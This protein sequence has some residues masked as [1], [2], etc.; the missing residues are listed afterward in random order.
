MSWE[1]SHPS[2]RNHRMYLSLTIDFQNCDLAIFAELWRGMSLFL[3][4]YINFLSR[5]GKSSVVHYLF[6]IFGF[7]KSVP[8]RYHIVC[9]CS[10]GYETSITA[11]C[12][13]LGD[14]RAFMYE[15]Q[16]FMSFLVC[17]LNV[18]SIFGNGGSHFNVFP[19]SPSIPIAQR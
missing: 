11:E 14:I 3:N 16:S 15:R 7:E 5:F 18:S 8:C 10:S 1:E 4:F 2:S 9:A 6:R 19:R 13:G 12:E 17:F